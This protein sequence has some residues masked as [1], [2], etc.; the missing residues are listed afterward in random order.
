MKNKWWDNS[1]IDRRTYILSKY[2][3]FDFTYD[4]LACI[5]MFDFVK[6]EK[7]SYDLE[8]VA[9]MLHTST[10]EI[11]AILTRLMERGWV[12]MR[13][14]NN[15]LDISFD[16]IYLN[17]P[18][19]C[20][21]MTLFDVFETQFK[22]TLSATEMNKLG[23]WKQKYEEETIKDALREATIYGK[24]SFTYID[25]I[26]INWELEDRNNEAK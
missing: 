1:Y 25:R 24:L 11:T 16:A 18:D 20:I 7:G 17:Q 23:E 21:P 15:K 9:D 22:R 6:Q 14:L 5:L 8:E 12:K 13:M 10:K 19:T 4:E 26:L 2:K 3:E